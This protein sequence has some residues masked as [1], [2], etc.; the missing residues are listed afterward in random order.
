[1]TERATRRA[2]LAMA[3]ASTGGCLSRVSS[4]AVAGGPIAWTNQTITRVHPRSPPPTIDPDRFRSL[5]RLVDM[6]GPNAEWRAG[7]G[8]TVA[9]DDGTRTLKSPEPFRGDRSLYVAGTSGAPVTAE[10]DRPVDFRDAHLSA[11]IYPDEPATTDPFQVHLF[12]PDR[13]NRITCLGNY[14]GFFDPG[15]RRYDFPVDDVVGDP[16]PADVRYIQFDVADAN[17]YTRCWIDDVRAVP[18]P[19]RGKVMFMFD[20]IPESAFTNGFR[21]MDEAG[22]RGAYGVIAD[23]VGRDGRLSVDQLNEAERA[24]WELVSHSKTGERLTALPSAV[25][26]DYLATTKEWLQV[27]ALR[28]EAAEHFVFPLAKYGRTSLANVADFH[29]MAYVGGRGSAP[30]LTDPLTIARR[31]GERRLERLQHLLG[32]AEAYR[33]LLILVFHTIDGE[34]VRTFRK[35]VAAVRRRRDR[36]RI[37]VLTPTELAALQTRLG[38]G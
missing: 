4:E 13:E 32:L 36:G 27:H 38:G 26:R 24:G 14:H 3:V 30:A 7:I 9:P 35:F 15:W 19:A 37:D 2:F 16:D 33:N 20:D 17:E 11:A 25:Q 12:A 31:S 18:K 5:G 8:M 10:F 21:I 34:F 29:E 28:P 1:M 6:V 22:L 23:I